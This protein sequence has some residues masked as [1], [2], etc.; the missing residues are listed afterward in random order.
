MRSI[1]ESESDESFFIDVETRESFVSVEELMGGG[2]VE[3]LGGREGEVEIG[4]RCRGQKPE[5]RG[6]W[7]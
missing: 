2:G 6:D 7:W 1:Y 4:E 5:P 3:L